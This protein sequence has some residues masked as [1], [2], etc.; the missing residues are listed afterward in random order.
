MWRTRFVG[1]LS[2]DQLASSNFQLSVL[3]LT[4]PSAD[5][6]GLITPP[7]CLGNFRLSDIGTILQTPPSTWVP[8]MGPLI[9][10]DG[11]LRG[12]F[13]LTVRYH[14]ETDG[15]IPLSPHSE[16]S[17]VRGGLPHHSAL[18]PRRPSQD[19]HVSAASVAPSIKSAG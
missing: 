12:I 18:P 15:A 17:S 19:S 7:T 10:D 3:A 6:T 13:S 9:S 8:I 4:L 16:T 5:H 11:V 2:F 1:Q 14:K